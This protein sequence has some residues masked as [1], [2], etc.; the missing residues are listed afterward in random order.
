MAYGMAM[1]APVALIVSALAASAEGADHPTRPIAWSPHRRRAACTTW[2]G[3][4]GPS[5]SRSSVLGTVVVEQP[6]GAG[7]LILVPTQVVKAEP[8]GYT[9]LL[10]STSSDII[11]PGHCRAGSVRPAEGSPADCG[12][13]RGSTSIA[14]TSL[15]P[16]KT[17]GQ[18]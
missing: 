1:A 7:T 2:S 11:A 8:D 15:L 6:P 13:D 17:L 16:V 14:V 18:S 10:G 4:C 5:A 9:L 3:G 12:D